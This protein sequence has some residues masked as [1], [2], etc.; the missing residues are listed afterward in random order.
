MMS[1]K[2]LSSSITPWPELSY[3]VYIS[4]SKKQLKSKCQRYLTAGS[5]ILRYATRT[6]LPTSNQFV[7][8][9]RVSSFK[10]GSVTLAVNA[11]FTDDAWSKTNV[12]FPAA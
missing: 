5:S 11:P 7:E 6:E 8:S 4:T 2:L 9:A 10:A 3:V 1:R 12:L